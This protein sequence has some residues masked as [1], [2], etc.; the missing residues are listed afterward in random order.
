MNFIDSLLVQKQQSGQGR[1]RRLWSIS[2]E[3]VWL[4]VF[5][6][7][8]AEGKTAISHEALGAPLR[9]SRYAD[10]SVK[11]SRTGR[12]VFKVAPEI[13]TQVS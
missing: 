6:A 10:G 4:P 3:G 11:F 2:L 9:L 5:I 7:T 1:D 12:P 13:A 8:N